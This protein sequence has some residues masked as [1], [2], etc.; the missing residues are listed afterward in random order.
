M[1]ELLYARSVGKEL[2]KIPKKDLQRIIVKIQHLAKTPI[3]ET[4]LQLKG[5][6]DTYRIRHGNYRVVYRVD[7]GTVT[8]LIL[9]VAHRKDVYRN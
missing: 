4:A 1:Y 7:E 5:T 9:R 2:R 8:I 6:E 3:P